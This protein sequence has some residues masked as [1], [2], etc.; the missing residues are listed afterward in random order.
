[1]ARSGAL[2]ALIGAVASGPVSFALV[3]VLHPQPAWRDAELFAASYHPLQLLPFVFG[4]LLVGG[5]AV[6][7]AGLHHLA[8]PTQQP[9]TLAGLVFTSA[10]AGLVFLNYFAQT[11]LVPGW[12]TPYAPEHAAGVAIFSMS[13]PRSLAWAIEMGAYGLLGVATWFQAT[14]FAGTRLAHVTRALFVA[15]GV[16]SVVGTLWTIAIPGWVMTNI[17]LFAFAGWNVLII[18]A[19]ACAWR[20]LGE[21]D[22]SV[23]QAA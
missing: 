22:R 2:C 15:N 19:T 14:V 5:F 4:F 3:Q 7:A 8:S 16:M 23:L 6:L 10:F 12:V 20:V 17:G 11:I 13:N 18:T 21:T 9:R 1:M